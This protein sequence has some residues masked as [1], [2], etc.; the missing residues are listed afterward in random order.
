[1]LLML[2]IMQCV[3]SV[4]TR[5]IP[6]IRC[7]SRERG[8]FCSTPFDEERTICTSCFHTEQHLAAQGTHI[9]RQERAALLKMM[10]VMQ[11]QPDSVDHSHS[12]THSHHFEPLRPVFETMCFSNLCSVSDEPLGT[13]YRST[14]RKAIDWYQQCG[15]EDRLTKKARLHAGKEAEDKEMMPWKDRVSAIES[16]FDALRHH[17]QAAASQKDI[18]VHEKQ[19]LGEKLAISI[20]SLATMQ[21]EFIEKKESR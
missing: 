11:K 2:G 12:E 14:V 7:S 13:M 15:S 3:F 10:R 18:Q 1:M 9:R 16:G 8:L 5:T 19:A 6:W 4:S 17:I 20:S 21:Q